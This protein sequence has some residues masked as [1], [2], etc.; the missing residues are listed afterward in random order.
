MSGRKGVWNGRSVIFILFSF[1]IFFSLVNYP[2]Y[3]PYEHGANNNKKHKFTAP[4]VTSTLSF[5]HSYDPLKIIPIVEPDQVSRILLVTYFRSGSSFLGDLLQQNFR[6]F[7]TF[8]PLH[9]LESG[10]GTRIHDDK[11][12]D[13]AKLIN[14]IL[15]CN[16]PLISPYI[17]WALRPENR[18]LFK[19]NTFLW[20]TCRFKPVSCFNPSFLKETCIRS[21]L[22][23]LKFTRLHMR[24]VNKYFSSLDPSPSYSPSSFLP[25]TDQGHRHIVQTNYQFGTGL[26]G[27]DLGPSKLDWIRPT[28][29]ASQ[30]TFRD[31][32]HEFNIEVGPK[33]T[34]GN[35]G[36]IIESDLEQIPASVDERVAGDQA[37]IFK[38]SLNVVFLVRDP[39]GIYNSRKNR[40]WCLNSSCSSIRSL[41]KEMSEDIIEFEQLKRFQPGKFHLIRYED[42]SLDPV[43]TASELFNRLRI[44]FSNS[45]K[46]FLR[47]H[48]HLKA[49]LNSHRFSRTAQG[50]ASGDDDPYSTRR[51]SKDV[52]YGWKQEL[53]NSDLSAIEM[54]C[55]KVID[56]LGYRSV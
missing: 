37:G 13:A 33:S 46:W 26:L 32:H 40:T 23:V 53:T 36:N 49:G 29:N 25:S 12:E 10:K 6:T 43:G 35:V 48:T 45:V 56:K 22:Q 5:F 52:V 3:A 17:K 39:R 54:H 19:W 47:S 44:P 28:S 24:H 8:E 31:G 14:N 18:F 55:S 11:F 50:A 34:A 7:Y 16:F 21:P 42:L 41:C 51:N 20:S 15:K 27:D 1:L 4:T 30:G 9:Y 2:Y 38:N